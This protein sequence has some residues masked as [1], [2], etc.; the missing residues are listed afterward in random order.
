MAEPPSSCGPHGLPLCP[1]HSAAATPPSLPSCPF[2]GPL[3]LRHR[4]AQ[5]SLGASLAC[6]SST[7]GSAPTPPAQRPSLTAPKS[8]ALLSDCVFCKGTELG[9]QRDQQRGRNRLGRGGAG[10]HRIGVPQAATA[11]R[12]GPSCFPPT[13]LSARK[14]SLG[15]A[16]RPRH[17]PRGWH[18]TPLADHSSRKGMST[19]P[20]P[21]RAWGL[22]DQREAG[23]QHPLL[24][25]CSPAPATHLFSGPGHRRHQE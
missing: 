13:C 21:S 11:R 5:P 17:V 18:W 19:S 12:Y 25:A 7:L 4:G 2:P 16:L 23:R 8:P 6:P 24:R 15:A 3:P 22:Q 14:G 20:E 10:L 1:P 9:F